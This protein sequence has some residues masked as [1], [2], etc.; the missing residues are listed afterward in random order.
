MKLYRED[1]KYHDLIVIGTIIILAILL[2]MTL[3]TGSAT[4]WKIALGVATMA[5]I[6]YV[7]SCLRLKIRI[8][9]KKLTVR[10]AP[11]PFTRV[12][13]AKDEVTNIE[14]IS[15]DTPDLANSLAI[16]YGNRVRVFNFGDRQGMVIRYA[17]GRYVVVLSKKLFEN[18]DEVIDQLK[19][20]GWELA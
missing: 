16:R 8:S 17:D 4:P 13:V 12:K 10:I 5:L 9:P 20:N 14:F 11:I 15:S 1:Q 3:I 7:V 2:A 6:V 18:R 19:D